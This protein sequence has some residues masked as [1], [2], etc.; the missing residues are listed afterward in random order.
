MDRVSGTRCENGRTYIAFLLYM[1]RESSVFGLFLLHQIE[2]AVWIYPFCRLY[3]RLDCQIRVIY[4][5]YY[6]VYI[7]LHLVQCHCP[8]RIVTC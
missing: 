8:F 2:N 5:I 6:T 4:N 3:L 1:V 7:I